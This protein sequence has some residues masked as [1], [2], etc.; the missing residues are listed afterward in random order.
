MSVR[1][2]RFGD[3]WRKVFLRTYSV[4][5][6]RLQFSGVRGLRDDTVHFSSGITAIVGGNGVGKST[7]AHAVADVLAPGD[8]VPQLQPSGARVRGSVLTATLQDDAG[9]HEMSLVVDGDGA[10][11]SVVRL[12]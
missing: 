6:L 2:A 1:R 9:Q 11:T 7:L 4:R 5:Y 10:R 3:H 12:K 8:G